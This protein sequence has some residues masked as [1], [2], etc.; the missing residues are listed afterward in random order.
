M[1][2]DLKWAGSTGCTHGVVETWNDLNQE[3]FTDLLEGREK[4]T[5]WKGRGGKKTF[6]RLNF[7]QFLKNSNAM[8]GDIGS[9]TT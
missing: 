1:I 4:E 3:R 8:F 6:P 2:P 5:D 9:K 7:R